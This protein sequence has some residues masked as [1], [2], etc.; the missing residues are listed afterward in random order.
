MAVW[1]ANEEINEY[2]NDIEGLIEFGAMNLPRPDSTLYLISVFFLNGPQN[3]FFTFERVEESDA[4]KT[5]A[6]VNYLK[7]CQFVID[8]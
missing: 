2:H 5:H 4:E 3:H 1:I 8:Q 6:H 7:N